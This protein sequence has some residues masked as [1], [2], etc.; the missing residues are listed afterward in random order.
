[1]ETR[2][3]YVGAR[4]FTGAEAGMF[5]GRL[6]ESYQ[7][8]NLVV[9]NS[10]LL[11][12][13]PSGT[14]KSSFFNAR[15]VPLLEE[16]GFEIFPPLRVYNP[17]GS[18]VR[19]E[20]VK[21]V[22]VFNALRRCAEHHP[23]FMQLAHKTLADY[24]GEMERRSDPVGQPAPRALVFDQSEELFHIHP[25]RWQHRQE[26][27]QQVREALDNDR[28]L[29]VVFILREDSLGE[30][31]RYTELLPQR[32][33]E[34]FRL[35]RMNKAEALEALVGPLER[36]GRVFGKG[37]AEKL[38]D[39]LST[40]RVV[41]ETGSV[42]VASGEFV[43]PVQLQL[44][45]QALWQS[46]RPDEKVVTSERL[47]KLGDLDDTLIAFY[48]EVIRSVA[49]ANAEDEGEIRRWLEDNFIT[50]ADTLQQVTRGDRE[51]KGLSNAV[52]DELL[53]RHLIRAE[54]MRGVSWIELSHYRFVPPI[55]QSNARYFRARGA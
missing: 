53:R 20:E 15:I 17:P 3:P 21:N 2:E 46:L 7:V 4:P 8:L 49:Q 43:E 51:T 39:E 1:M 13:G 35:N 12:Y 27:F 48:D 44:I 5:F 54:T 30:F 10:V 14:G 55:R 41:D 34:R 18:G 19:P 25:E 23:D 38:I 11:L 29:R 24:L 36:A 40:I 22:F 28:R 45:G 6:R 52:L 16:Q 37:A 42:K 33:Q 26:F 31:L 32:W 9:V 50:P 47:A